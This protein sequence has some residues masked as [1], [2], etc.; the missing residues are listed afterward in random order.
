MNE[1]EAEHVK[2]NFCFRVFKCGVSVSYG[3]TETGAIAVNGI[4]V[5]G[6]D[7][8]LKDVPE[9]GYLSTDVP[10]RGELWVRSVTNSSGYYKVCTISSF[11]TLRPYLCLQDS[12]N[13]TANFEE[14]G[15]ANTGDIV[16]YD[17][18]TERIVIVDRK[19]NIFKLSQSEFVAPEKLEVLFINSSFIRNCYVYGNSLQSYVLAVVVPEF[20]IL[21]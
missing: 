3:T 15:W 8:K 6:V 13:T 9:M 1:R 10:P 17:K 2:L 20:T 16:S 12:A 4:R 18:K 21:E 7:V 5:A 11:I 19:K 14:G